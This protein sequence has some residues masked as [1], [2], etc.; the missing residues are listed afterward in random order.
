MLR[1]GVWLLMLTAAFVTCWTMVIQ[2][3]VTF[4]SYPVGTSE[5]TVEVKELNFPTV[6]ICNFNQIKKSVVS[7]DPII[8]S[9]ITSIG[10]TQVQYRLHPK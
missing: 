4:F 9:I 1:R 8:T 2:Q 7:S 10:H 5:T 6:T 3:T